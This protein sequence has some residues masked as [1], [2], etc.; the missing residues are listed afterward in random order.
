MALLQQD[1]DIREG[2]VILYPQTDQFV[3]Q[4]DPVDRE[5]GQK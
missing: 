1:V 4:D 3:V 5:P 2:T